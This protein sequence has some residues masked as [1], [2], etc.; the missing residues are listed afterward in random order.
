M[1]DFRTAG[2]PAFA[3]T[4]LALALAA[5][6]VGPDYVRPQLPTPEAFHGAVAAGSAITATP[7]AGAAAPAHAQAPAPAPAPASTADDRFWRD[8]GDPLLVQLVEDALSANHDLRIAFARYDR[9]NA[10]LRGAR[11]D[12][13]PTVTADAEAAT[14]R[15]SAT[16]EPGQLRSGRDAD[17]YRAGIAA[18]WEI[19]LFGRIRRSIEAGRADA[20]A[21]YAD[22]QAVQVAIA[23]ET[24]HAYLDLRGAQERLRVARGNA[25]NQRDTFKLV[26]ARF[27]AGRDSEFD[28]ARADAQLETTR[29]RIPAL[30]AQVASSIH[31]LG[32]LTGRTP[33]ALVEVLGEAAPLPALPAVI[34]PGTPGELLRSRPDVAAAEARL[35]AATARIGVA[36]AELF[37]RFTL[38]GLLGSQAA[39]VGA[40]FERDSGTRFVALGIDWSFLDV[41][42]VRTRIAAA[43]ADAAGELARYQQAVLLALEDTEN[44]LVRLDRARAEDAH[45]ERAARNS[46][47]AAELARIRFDAGAIGLLEVLDAERTRLQAEDAFAA[48]RTRSATAAVALYRALAGGWPHPLALAMDPVPEPR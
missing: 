29:A 31:R 8:F 22:M 48:A 43:D 16:Q 14:S 45:L 23:G 35:H 40:L 6:S 5:C 12:H 34:D 1:T 41:G 44:A 9:A 33:D 37:P 26:Q 17:S 20:L 19:D 21:S 42:R 24:T 10:L 18:A 7:D 36:T 2:R 32:V 11:L 39:D 46:A 13:L 4:L 25:G 30:E 3:S 28:T 15:A 27:D 47:R 38:G